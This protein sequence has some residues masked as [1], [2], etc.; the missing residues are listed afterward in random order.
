MTLGLLGN[1]FNIDGKYYKIK[2]DKVDVT[3]MVKSILEN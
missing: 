3:A 1:I 2:G